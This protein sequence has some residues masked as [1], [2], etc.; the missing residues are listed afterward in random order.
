MTHLVFTYKTKFVIIHYN[1]KRGDKMICPYCGC[2]TPNTN[3][4]AVCGKDTDV[5]IRTSSLSV[6]TL[7]LSKKSN[8]RNTEEIR[9]RKEI[10]K[11]ESAV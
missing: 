6:G 3:Q 5:E 4:C 11:D 10:D 1:S 9:D 8:A 7:N 2:A